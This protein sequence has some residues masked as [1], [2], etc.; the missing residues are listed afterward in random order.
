MHLINKKGMNTSYT[1]Q[2]NFTVQLILKEKNFNYI[3]NEQTVS[4]HR[5]DQ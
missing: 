5:H 3:R 4:D 2:I 1:Q